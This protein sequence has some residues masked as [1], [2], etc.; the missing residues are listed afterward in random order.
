MRFDDHYIPGHG[1]VVAQTEAIGAR[2]FL[3]VRKQRRRR[4]VLDWR[5]SGR[6]AAW[7]A[8]LL[9][10]QEVPGSNPGGPTK[11]STELQTQNGSRTNL[12]SPTGVQN[13]RR[14]PDGADE[15][16]SA[17][18]TTCCEAIYCRDLYGRSCVRRRFRGFRGKGQPRMPDGRR[19]GIAPYS[20]QLRQELQRRLLL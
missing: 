7:L 15:L 12:W 11:Y 4:R 18:L 9:G 8:R 14:N 3:Q 10:V 5:S 17:C 2:A 19:M 6:G 16:F 13:G 20:D 1:K